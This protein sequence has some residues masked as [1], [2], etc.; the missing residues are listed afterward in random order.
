VITNIDI[1]NDN[2]FFSCTLFDP[3]KTFTEIYPTFSSI[4]VSSTLNSTASTYSL[5]AISSFSLPQHIYPIVSSNFCHFHLNFFHLKSFVV[6]CSSFCITTGAIIF[7]I[8]SVIEHIRPKF[9]SKDP[10][11]AEKPKKIELSDEYLRSISNV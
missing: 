3:I 7:I 8:M 5:P 9:N 2:S 11:V 1:K 10:C 6:I 4:D